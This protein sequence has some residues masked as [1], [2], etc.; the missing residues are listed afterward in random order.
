MRHFKKWSILYA[1]LSAT[2]IALVAV[3]ALGGSA[4]PVSGDSQSEGW[5]FPTEQGDNEF[6]NAAWAEDEDG[7]C[8]PTNCATVEAGEAGEYITFGFS[9]PT[10]A[11]ITGIKVK[12]G[13][14]NGGAT[15]DQPKLRLVDETET[16]VGDEETVT[17]PASSYSSDE[18]GG[19]DELWGVSWTPAK[20]ND[21]DF[22]VE[23]T[24]AGDSGG[25]YLDYVKITVYYCEDCDGDGLDNDEDNCPMTPNPDQKNT[26]W[27]LGHSTPSAKYNGTPIGDEYGDACDDDD[28]DDKWDDLDEQSLPLPT[29]E[30]DNCYGGPPVGVTPAAGTESDAWP[31]D[32]NA[33]GSVDSTDI[34]IFSVAGFNAKADIWIR[35]RL[36][37]DGDTDVDI[38]DVLQLKPY[39]GHTC[40]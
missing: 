29:N 9:I 19:A 2:A 10:A 32:I 15:A 40:E 11:G 12:L 14:Y 33:S 30:Y 7:G 25:F 8:D 31:P 1:V 4:S 26:D 28:D 34:D 20:I 13:G 18:V 36:D 5:N 16:P 6:E 23:I 27:E 38:M 35:Q 3:L 22:G 39:L 24:D 17:L 37:M 21:A